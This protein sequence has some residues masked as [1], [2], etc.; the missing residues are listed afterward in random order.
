MNQNPLERQQ[1]QCPECKGVGTIPTPPS[2]VYDGYCMSE[3]AHCC[4]CGE[5]KTVLESDAAYIARLKWIAEW[6]AND[7]NYPDEFRDIHCPPHDN[8]DYVGCTHCRLA[9]AQ[10][11]WEKEQGK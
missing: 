1:V 3:R 10:T 9:A 6:L 7:M 8:C 5:K 4:T 11:A 2:W